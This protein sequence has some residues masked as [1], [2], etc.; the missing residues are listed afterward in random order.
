[1]AEKSGAALRLA[2]W[3][4]AFESAKVEAARLIETVATNVGSRGLSAVG[5][6]PVVTEA[7]RSIASRI[8]ADAA[9]FDAKQAKCELLRV[10]ASQ[11]CDNP[12]SEI[13]RHELVEYLRSAIKRI[14]AW[15]TSLPEIG[16]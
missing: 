12:F 16:R 6:H 9:A 2:C 7:I 3:N 15:I 11:E 10:R 8:V 4:A 13:H 5:F 1:M 14:P